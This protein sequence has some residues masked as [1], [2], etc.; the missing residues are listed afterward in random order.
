[1]WPY[2]PGSKK[3]PKITSYT[4]TRF[5]RH[6]TRL[7]SRYKYKTTNPVLKLSCLRRPPF[8]TMN[9]IKANYWQIPW[10]ESL[11][12]WGWGRRRIPVCRWMLMK[13]FNRISILKW[14]EVASRETHHL[15]AVDYF[16]D[17]ELNSTNFHCQFR[18]SEREQDKYGK[19]DFNNII[20]F[21]TFPSDAEKLRSD[22]YWLR[23]PP[24]VTGHYIVK[25]R[26]LEGSTLSRR[27][28]IFCKFTS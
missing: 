25:W 3:Y 24:P 14:G 4:D 22:C 21:H 5:L 10:N 13:K 12:V 9:I 7:E 16:A 27:K 8:Y 28:K 19:L 1:M 6:G 18:P 17:T 11:N 2:S 26:C 15:R 23:C 20:L